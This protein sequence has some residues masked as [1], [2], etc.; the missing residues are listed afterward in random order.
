[1]GTLSSHRLGLRLTLGFLI[2]AL[3]PLAGLAWFYLHTFER[4][5]TATV[6]QNI[7]SIA[8]KKADQIDSYI[9]ERLVDARSFASQTMVREALSALVA[10]RTLSTG[11]RTEL[12]TLGER[13]DYHDLLLIDANGDVVFSLRGEP[14]LGTNLLHGPFRDSELAAGFRQAMTFMHIDMT[15]FA[16][17][18]PSGGEVA[19]FVVAPIL[20]AQRPIGALAL[21]VNLT[22]LM[23]VVSDRTGL[24]TSGETVLAVQD[25]QAALYTVSLERMPGTPFTN[26]VPLTQIAEPM[27]LALTGNQGHGIV[28]DYGD[29]DVAAGWRYLPALGWGMVVKIDTAEVLAPL[30]AMQKATVLAFAVFLLASAS[31]AL[32][33]GRRLVRDERIIAA[34]QTR[35]RA[36]LG[37]MNDGVALFRPL[38]DGSEFTLLDI[39][40]AGERITGVKRR[41]VLGRPSRIAFPGLDAAG[42]YAAFG[43][44]LRRGGSETIGLTAY[45]KDRHSLWLQTD[46]IRLQGGEILAVFKDITARKTADERIEHLAHHDSLTGLVN[47]RNLE[48]L[49]SQALH[50][51][52]REG[53]LLAVLFIDLDRFKVI[54]DTLGHHIGDLL[55]VEVAHRLCRDMRE[56]DIVARQGGDEFVVVLT[57]LECAQDAAVVAAKILLALGEPYD[58]EGD[59]L[60]TSPSI[61]I[62]IYPDD[63]LDADT[64]TKNADTA[65]YHAKEQGRNN[66]QFFTEALN[67][68]AGERLT[69]ERELRVAIEEGQLAVYYQPQLE[70]AADPLGYPF[71]MEALVRWRHPHRGLITAGHFIPIA[72]ESG[73]IH[74]IGDWVLNEACRRFREWTH[75]GIGPRRIAVNLSAHQLR[76]PA[77]LDTVAAVLQRYELHEDELELEV[78][79]SVAM[80]DPARAVE[81]LQALRNLGVRLA[82]DDFG[83]GHSSLA[84]LKRLPIQTLKLDREFVRDIE[85]D[86][87]D[88][89]ISAATLALAHELG[90]RVVAEGIETEGQ[91]RFLRAHGCDLLQGYFYGKPEPAEF[92][93]AHW[94]EESRKSS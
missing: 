67:L 40:A 82:I 87:N 7:T 92:W 21:Q 85:T 43:R 35:Y 6:L 2:V 55:L 76:N 37:S 20:D 52:H 54:N 83:T 34:Q 47:R 13:A 26:P 3:L 81:T 4:A 69:V 53:R 24:G 5:L 30:H 28:S 31:A 15:R 16:P 79:E 42:I 9:N 59:R 58:I 62:S 25:G 10:T 56:S 51:A 50:A 17:Y 48:I 18:A 33:L 63:G 88:A 77:L 32:V 72:E 64:L 84:Y 73:L 23:P 68:A 80:R 46:V 94:T 8:D 38:A 70:A 86:E 66:I 65:M 22:T 14:D 36:M 39:N 19:A 41:E 78:T 93:T 1:M 29:I 27:Q 91:S 11:A 44:V 49:L 61:G 57:A 71:A 60:H 12:A 74:T 89:A 75:A 90:L 45:V